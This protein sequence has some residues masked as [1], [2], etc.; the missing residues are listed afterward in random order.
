M[1]QQA[2]QATGGALLDS[3]LDALNG[4][5]TQLFGGLFKA[6][7]VYYADA[8]NGSDSND[9][10]SAENAFQTLS[11]AY[12]ATTSGNNDVVVIVGNGQ[13]SG[14][15]R[16]SATFTWA[17]DA[18]HLVGVCS[19]VLYS[20]RARI[21]PTAGATAF[22]NFFVISGDGCIFE[23]I[24]WF[25]GFTTGT[26]SQICVNISGERNYFRNCHFAGMGDQESADN[27]GSRSLKIG[28][29]GTGENVFDSCVIGLDTVTR[30][31]ANA[32][33]E[34]AGATPRN[35]F[36]NCILPFQADAATPLAILTSGSGSMD[37]HQVFDRCVFVN[38]ISS[39]ST[40]LT[41]ATT[42]AASSGG[43]IFLKDCSAVGITDWFS[44]A[45]T[46]GQ[47]RID[48]AAPTA[49]TSGLAVQPT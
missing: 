16:L 48:G 44:D 6:G 4:N 47:M 20:Q 12:N 35:V 5:F 19:P 9:G 31:A 33:I 32:S 7:T 15:Q 22:A 18:T 38:N 3:T 36:R 24:Q 1:S 28:S 49:A 2:L 45:T 23:N 14:S 34:F 25:H 27:S 13:A 30:G 40:T 46:A 41:A 10:L 11:A 8:A 26:T 37:R 17:K 29:G 43:L 42:L 21:A 39:T